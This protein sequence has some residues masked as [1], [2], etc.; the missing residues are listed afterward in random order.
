MTVESDPVPAALRR[1]WWL[2]VV[3]ALLA[4]T[5]VA[6]V[7]V[8][9][10][11]PT[12]AVLWFLVTL[13]PLGYTLWLLR[14]S[15]SLNRPPADDDGSDAVPDGGTAVFPTLGM[16][17]G[18]TLGR[19]WLYAGV[20]GFLLVT[21]A[22]DSVWRWLPALWYGGGAALD[23]VDG[24]VACHV[25][26]PTR[27][28]ERLDLAFDTMGFLVAP[29]VA[30]AWGAL[31]PWYLAVSVARYCYRFGCWLH[32]RRGGTIRALPES[33]LRRPLAGLQMAVVALALLPVVPTGV[34]WLAATLAMLPSLAVFCRDFLSVT[35][36]LGVPNIQDSPNPP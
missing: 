17:N 30:V 22:A 31:P 2:T 7:A 33:R 1:R 6:A 23:W 13:V 12:A 14:R 32:E 16:A 10:L 34:A 9:T 18:I 27:L 15:L 21:P 25:G 28:G 3:V 36:R 29:V 26:R 8:Q 19:G 24:S 11:S 4:A 5:V 35:G 20:A